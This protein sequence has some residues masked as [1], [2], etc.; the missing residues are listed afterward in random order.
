M[1]LATIMFPFGRSWLSI[2]MH[3]VDESAPRPPLQMLLS[4][5]EM[6]RLRIFYDNTLDTLF[7]R[8]DGSTERIRRRHGHAFYIWNPQIRCLFT[9]PQL[10]RLHRRFGHPGYVKLYKCPRRERP[11][12]VDPDTLTVLKQIEHECRACRM[13]Q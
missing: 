10:Q 13:N 9:R 5:A 1:G 8:T 3:I 11:D 6:D 7:R 4:L 2:Q 12:E